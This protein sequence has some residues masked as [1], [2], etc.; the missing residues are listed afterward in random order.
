MASLGPSAG[1][2]DIGSLPR[3]IVQA[4]YHVATGKTENMKK[5]LHGDV[6]ISFN[7]LKSLHNALTEQMEHYDIVSGPTVTV[8]VKLANERSITYSSWERFE[9]LEVSSNELTSD[10]TIKYELVFRLPKTETDQRC[11]I[12]IKLDSSLPVISDSKHMRQMSNLGF[13]LLYAQEWESAVI[14]IDF[15]DFLIAKVFCTVVEEW[16]KQLKRSSAPVRMPNLRHYHRIFDVLSAQIGRLGMALFFAIFAWISGKGMDLQKVVYAVSIA[17]AIWATYFL[18][19][20]KVSRY[21]LE[22]V[23][24]NT[25]PAIIVLNPCD[26]N[27]IDEISKRAVSPIK[28]IFG[29]VLTCISGLLLN[30]IASYTYSF[31]TSSQP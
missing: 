15:V 16:F 27:A 9:K 22:K 29:M 5:S 11:I 28:L 24:G 2:F 8:V 17:L 25:I 12:N 1:T 18:I 26:Q 31:L 14:S 20:D 7:D 23:N 3:S 19:R 30:I 10:I 13:A 21:I 4:V 6:L